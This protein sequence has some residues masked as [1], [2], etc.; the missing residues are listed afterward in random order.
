[1]STLLTLLLP[2]IAPA[3]TDGFRALVTRAVNGKGKGVEAPSAPENSIAYINAETARIDAMARL[4]AVTGTPSQ[5]VV[6][7]RAVFRYAA[8]FFIWVIT[9]IAVFSKQDI[10]VIFTLLDI[11]GATSSFIIGERFYLKIKNR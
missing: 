4:D 3:L 2:A 6:N 5:W 11:C 8:I 10:T 9:A 7:I 1:M